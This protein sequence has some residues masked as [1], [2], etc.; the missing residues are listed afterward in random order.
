[1]RI[2]AAV[3]FGAAIIVNALAVRLPLNDRTTGELSDLYPNLFVPAGITFSIWSVIYVVVAAWTVAQFTR[4]G[5]ELGER[6]APAFALSSVLNAAWI[7]AWHYEQ[8]ALSVLIMLGLLATL[9]RIN[10]LLLRDAGGRRLPRAAFG[11]YLGWICVATVANVT[12]LLV[13]LGWDGAG[14]S[15]AAWAT[16][17]VVG[18]AVAA[19]FA[20]LRLDNPYIGAAVVWALAGIVLNRW[21]DV[22]V[23]AFTAIAMALVVGAVAIRTATAPGGTGLAANA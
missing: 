1:M 8:V 20:V 21:D 17:L 11:V 14:I 2:L 6:V 18:A 4:G 12:T 9:L 19:S 22:R 16:V 5:R 23:I 15:A 13:A 10:T 3:A 7:F